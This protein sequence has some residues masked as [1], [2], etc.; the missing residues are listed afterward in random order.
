MALPRVVS[1]E[2]LDHLAA[3]DP[4]AQ[5][6]RRDLLRVHRAMGTR[7]IVA[8]AWQALL[9]TH[10]AA[11]P[12][13]ILELG[14][15]DGS[16]LLGVARLLAPAWPPV[17]LTLLDRQDIVSPAT[18]AGYAAL[19]WTVEVQRA[20]VLDWAARAAQAPADAPPWDLVSTSLFLHHFE[21]AQLDALLAGIARSATRFVACEPR[22]EWLAL[23]GSHLVAAIG[24]NA[25]TRH[26]AVASVHAGFRG[27]ELTV[28]WPGPA[29]AWQCREFGAGLFGHVFSAQ[30]VGAA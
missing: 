19:G 1:A 22:R 30:R 27:S 4:A 11:A 14:A 29:A 6:S 17:H 26:D 16:L 8:R 2:G 13:K 21:G 24:A 9:P 12:L 25:V 5:R 23:G 20:D 18:R 10:R 28:A 3:S 15:G 7:A